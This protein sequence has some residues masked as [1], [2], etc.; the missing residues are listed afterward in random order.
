MAERYGTDTTLLEWG[1]RPV[2]SACGSH[3]VDMVVTAAERRWCRKGRL[4][5]SIKT[6]QLETL[7]GNAIRSSTNPRRRSRHGL[8]ARSCRLRTRSRPD[9][10]ARHSPGSYVRARFQN[11]VP[12][13]ERSDAPVTAAAH[14]IFKDAIAWRKRAHLQVGAR[15]HMVEAE[16]VDPC[17]A[18]RV[19][20]R[21]LVH[22]RREG[23]DG[24]TA[25]VER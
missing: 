15:L 5:R 14:R 10:P 9:R 1:E 16:H 3:N 20:R 19:Q 2:Y 17:D 4:T 7:A 21:K 13:D 25:R 12:A 11:A 24:V 6:E 22:V 18:D 8:R 23:S